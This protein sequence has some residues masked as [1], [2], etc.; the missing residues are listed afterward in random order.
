MFDL[1][2]TQKAEYQAQAPA[3]EAMFAQLDVIKKAVSE[4]KIEFDKLDMGVEVRTFK[5]ED[6]QKGTNLVGN[7]DENMELMFMLAYI[8][9]F[10]TGFLVN[11]KMTNPNVA[12]ALQQSSVAGAIHG[13]VHHHMVKKHSN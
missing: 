3:R 10:F 7:R 8:S 6:I 1:D 2:E 9:A 11:E 13:Q 12:V 5:I 4:I